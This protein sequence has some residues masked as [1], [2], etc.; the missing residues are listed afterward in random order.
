ML[1]PP[2]VIEPCC[3]YSWKIFF[4]TDHRMPKENQ[5]DFLLSFYTCAFHQ[6]L[7]F[8]NR[9]YFLYLDF[10]YS[11]CPWWLRRNIIKSVKSLMAR[12]KDLFSRFSSSRTKQFIFLSSFYSFSLPSF[13]PFFSHSNRVP[14]AIAQLIIFRVNPHSDFYHYILDLFI[15]LNNSFMLGFF[16]P[17]KIFSLRLIHIV[18]YNCVL[19]F[20]IVE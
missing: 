16:L 10:L 11:L 1:W 3:I 9:K 13:L 12:T 2:E 6:F 5:Q 4:M 17:L 19:W 15:F 8:I 18:K 14:C 7:I 20:F